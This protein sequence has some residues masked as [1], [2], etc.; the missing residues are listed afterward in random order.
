MVFYNLS[1]L[2]LVK[3]WNLEIGLPDVIFVAGDDALGELIGRF[4]MMPLF[5]LCS[6]VCPDNLEATL[7]AMLMALLNFGSTVGD[8]F[9]SALCDAFGVKNGN[10]DMLP[11][12]VISKSLCRLLAIPLIFIL[13]PNLTPEDPI[14]GADPRG[15]ADDDAANPDIEES[16]DT[17]AAAAT[18]PDGRDAAASMAGSMD[19][20][21]KPPRCESLSKISTRSSFPTSQ[22][23]IQTSPRAIEVTPE[24]AI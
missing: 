18:V 3:R 15:A 1:D 22:R 16:V 11:M 21:G 23:S 14:P 19:S 24:E 10:F 6:K 17:A 5:V 20:E 8:F 7:F 4:F 13:V 12:A 9:G 2:I